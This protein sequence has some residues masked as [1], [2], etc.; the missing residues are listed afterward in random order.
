MGESQFFGVEES[1]EK[2]RLAVPA[3]H[4]IELGDRASPSRLDLGPAET[5]AAAAEIS[6]RPR[7]RVAVS[8]SSVMD[9]SFSF[10]PSFVPGLPGCG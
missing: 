2:V 10:L 8:I 3:G 9:P 7:S 6:S 4:P 5:T 1:G